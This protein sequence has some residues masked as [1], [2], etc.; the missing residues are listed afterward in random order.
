MGIPTSEGELMLDSGIDTLL[1]FR[2]SSEPA[3]AH[4]NSAS[5]LSAN[6]SV[7][8]APALRIGDR[9]YHPANAV[10]EAVAN[11]PGQ[12]LLPASMFHAIYISNS[13]GFVIFDPET[14]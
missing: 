2:K 14:R 4:V 3:T 10:F 8:Y 6:V 9:V 12:G 13:E 7:G 1:F 11:A 5:G